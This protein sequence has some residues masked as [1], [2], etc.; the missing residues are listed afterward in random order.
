MDKITFT[1]DGAEV[2][3]DKGTTI[4]QAALQ[5]DIYIPHLCHH[6]DLKPSGVCRLCMVEVAGE[7]ALSCR[8][9]VRE[10]LSVKTRSPEIDK[11]RRANIEI[12][13][14][15]HHVT[16]KGCAGTGHCSLQKIM[17]YIRIDRKR[18]RRLRLP[19]EEL[20][21]D[22][23]N[24]FFDCDPNKC[25]LCGICVHTCIPIQHAM[26]IVGRGPKTK[27]AFFG[28]SSLCESC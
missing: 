13:V 20:P 25:V 9:P 3:T 4:L 6:P 17:S 5:N 26:N 22:T 10:G 12:L 7:A 8:T 19:K 27:I 1:I 21:I 14:A 15:N 18:V 28:D 16:C 2:V 23:S 24:P 11:A